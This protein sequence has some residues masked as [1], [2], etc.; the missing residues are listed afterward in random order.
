MLK[1]LHVVST[2][3]RS[4]GVMSFIM[5][6][7]RNINRSSIQ[8]DFL[9]WV[10][11]NGTY[12]EEIEELGGRVY[13][14]K[15]PGFSKNSFF[16]ILSFFKDNS[17]KYKILHLHEVYLNSLFSILGR[18]YGVRHIISHSHTT[19]YS[20]KKINAIRNR[21]LC[22]PLKKNVDAYFACSQAAGNFLYGK[23]LMKQGKIK[24]I[25]NAVDSKKFEFNE[26]IRTKVRN[27]LKLDKELVIGH[28]GR[29]NKQKNHEF[30]IEIFSEVFKKNKNSILLLIGMGP[31]EEEIKEK[32]KLYSLSD[33]VLFLGQREDVRDLLHAMDV[34]VLP[35]IFEGLGIVLIE[36]QMTGLQC[37]T[38]D[39]VP[40]EAKVTEN[41]SYLSLKSAASVWAERILETKNDS[42]RTNETNKIRNAGF[43]IRIEAKKLESYYLKMKNL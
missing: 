39:I 41:I 30:L 4:S 42:V 35:S 17:D 1:V 18:K 31:L 38:S 37:Y 32:V 3:S 25:N 14:V 9:Y 8:F 6:Y 13:F 19:K 27:N 16:S 2:L 20:D 40:I 21:I 22:L 33:Q 28:V 5:S 12:A 10:D 23:R 29:F 7:Y 11:S 43:D 15:K 24:I 34:F 26:K 36:A